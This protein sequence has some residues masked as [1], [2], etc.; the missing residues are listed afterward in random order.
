MKV[1]ILRHVR[2]WPQPGLVIDIPKVVAIPH[3]EAGHCEAMD[4]KKRRKKKKAAEK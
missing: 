3:I 4:R 2:G 1:K